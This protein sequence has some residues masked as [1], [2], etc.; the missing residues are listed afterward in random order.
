MCP[1]F[2]VWI[3]KLKHETILMHQKISASALRLM[4]ETSL[5]NWWLF[6]NQPLIRQSIFAQED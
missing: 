5:H 3:K 1:L 2:C 4:H 6:A